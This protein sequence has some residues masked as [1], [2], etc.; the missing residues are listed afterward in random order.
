[1]D[2]LR[3]AIDTARDVLETTSEGHSNLSDSIASSH[4]ILQSNLDAMSAAGDLH[5][6]IRSVEVTMETPSDLLTIVKSLSDLANTLYTMRKYDAAEGIYRRALERKEKM[7]GAEHV[8]TLASV[9]SLACML[10]CRG[11]YQEA[12]EMFR[13]ALKGREKALGLENIET[14]ASTDGLAEVTRLRR[15]YESGDSKA[16]NIPGN[17]PSQDENQERQFEELRPTSLKRIETSGAV[18]EKGHTYGPSIDMAEELMTSGGP[19][20]HLVQSS[21]RTSEEPEMTETPDSDTGDECLSDD[22]EDDLT[23]PTEYESPL[24][25]LRDRI[26]N[27]IQ[28]FSRLRALELTVYQHSTVN[29]YATEYSSRATLRSKNPSELCAQYPNSLGG[30][31]ADI[32]SPLQDSNALKV[33]HEASMVNSAFAEDLRGVLESRNVIVK[34][35]LNLKRLQ[36]DGFCVQKFSVLVVDPSRYNVARLLPI[37]IGQ[38]LHLVH[39]VESV[40]RKVADF[41][42]TTASVSTASTEELFLQALGKQGDPF[43]SVPL[44]KKFLIN[45]GLTVEAPSTSSFGTFRFQVPLAIRLVVNTIDLA[46]LSYTGAHLGRFD[47]EYLGEDISVIDVLAPFTGGDGPNIPSIKLRRCPLQCLGSFHDN[48]PVWVF[49][50]NDWEPPGSLFLSTQVEDFADIWGPLWKAID[51]EKL[52]TYS[53]YVVG[54]GSIFKWQ[55]TNLTPPLSHGEVLCH[56]V[57][58]HEL[59]KEPELN[60]GSDQVF[61]ANR[62]RSNFDGMETMLIGAV[63]AGCERLWANKRCDIDLAKARAQIKD[64]GRLRMLGVVEEH[65]YRDSETYQLQVGHSGVNATVAR[66]YKRRVQ[67]LKMAL[68]ELWAMTPEIRDPQLLEDFYGLEVSM[69]THNAQRVQ[70]ARVLGLKC[71]RQYLKTF[72]WKDDHRRTAFFEALQRFER[73][74]NALRQLWQDFPEYRDEFGQAVMVCLKALEQTGINHNKELDVFLSSEVAARPELATL[75]AKE[76]SWIGLLKDSVDS[77]SMAVFGDDCLEFNHETGISCGG[78]GRSVLRTALVINQLNRPTGLARKCAYRHEASERWASRWSVSAME[79]GSDIWLGE[80]G[81]LRLLSHLPEA[82]LLM[83]WR[84]SHVSTVFKNLIGK[85]KPHRE[86]IEIDHIAT[87]PIR[88]IPLFIITH[89]GAN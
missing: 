22:G 42:K 6:A 28:Y 55:P 74:K 11:Q 59:E 57:S 17:L 73:N 54:N 88:P 71:M 70:L 16:Y 76:H 75:K 3:E 80:H 89:V 9:D 31:A 5:K 13:R 48:Q 64:E 68:V 50:S 44:C 32:P 14:L 79:V 58:D 15:K 40:L 39:E 77:C 27:P 10:M 34:A 35:Y 84:A 63:V 81:T 47:Q 1:M 24:A 61:L 2:D 86:F 4:Q 49:S 38:I 65:K 21:S 19:T 12:E 53:R 8:N 66:Q 25:S 56:W 7:L 67:S 33:Y 87:R 26:A 41:S 18:F 78:A 82:T 23:S 52:D 51:C 37:E 72:M 85:E 45:F 30:L 46:V 29:I 20:E 69:C 60:P 36:L 43:A 62:V 83:E